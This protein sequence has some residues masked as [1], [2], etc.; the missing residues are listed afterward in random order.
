MGNCFVD[1][2]TLQIPF[3]MWSLWYLCEIQS[4]RIPTNRRKIQILEGHGEMKSKG[5]KAWISSQQ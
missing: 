1:G 4:I 3:N 5:E 2:M